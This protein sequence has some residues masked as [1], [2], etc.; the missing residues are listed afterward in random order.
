MNAIDANLPATTSKNP[1]TQEASSW[2]GRAISL[3][4]FAKIP[5]IS[6]L[7]KAAVFIPLAFYRLS[8]T[9]TAIL[10]GSYLVVDL[11]LKGDSDSIND[12]QK[13]PQAGIDL[14]N[15]GG[16][17]LAVA[18][19]RTSVVRSLIEKGIEINPSALL[20]A[21]INGHLDVVKLLVENGAD[22]NATNETGKT[23]LLVAAAARNVGIVR[24]LIE[25]GADITHKDNVGNT[26]LSL[27][28]SNKHI[29][30]VRILD[31]A[32]APK[33]TNLLTREER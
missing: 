15:E 31:N 16:A 1:S 6:L 29:D 9:E 23:P 27:A 2:S 21:T 28:V 18:K 14:T 3:L 17:L 8:Y 30:I 7:F 19:G 4:S 20:L 25:Q 5:L 26:A 10:Y 32:N 22:L 11:M 13:I 24:F 12:E 33:V